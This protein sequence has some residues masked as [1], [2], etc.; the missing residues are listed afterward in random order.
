VKAIGDDRRT[1]AMVRRA[2]GGEG[3]RRGGG[4]AYAKGVLW[5]VGKAVWRVGSRGVQGAGDRQPVLG[6]VWG[7]RGRFPRGGGGKAG[8]VGADERERY[9]YGGAVSVARASGG[10]NHEMGCSS[11]GFWGLRSERGR[12]GGGVQCCTE[13][14]R[15]RARG[16]ASESRGRY[17]SGG[18]RGGG[19]G[20][21]GW[22]RAHEAAWRIGDDF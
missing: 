18:G 15:Q 12:F 20:R 1:R 21:W 8:E 2:V 11:G 22:G 13:C 5:S 7:V 10:R 17:R 6:W 16:G 4:E 19:G 3:I 9:Y 14:T